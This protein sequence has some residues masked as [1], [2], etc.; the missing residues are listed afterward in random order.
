MKKVAFLISSAGTGGGIQKSLSLITKELG[1]E[2][3]EVTIISLFDFNKT[4]YDYGDATRI[5]KGELEGNIDLKKNFIKTYLECNRLLKLADYD[6]LVVE[7]LGLVPFLRKKI[8]NS[9]SIKIIVRDHSGLS[10]YSKFGLS[11]I[12]LKKTL[13]YANSF[14]VLTEENKK[15][16]IDLSNRFK[17]IIKVI[18]NSIDPDVKEEKYNINSKK[19]IF[20]GRL[21]RE[22][23]VDLLI[24]SFSQS[25]FE[26]QNLDWELDIYGLG[27]EEKNIRDL[28]KKKGLEDRIYLKGYKKNVYNIYHEYSFMVVAS[29]FE[30]FGLA[31]VEAFKVGIPVISFDCN[32][33]PRSIITNN[34]N[35][36]LVKANDV[37]AL[38][39]AINKLIRDTEM[40]KSFSVNTRNGI[41]KYSHQN[42]INEWKKIL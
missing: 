26:L 2:H 17:N 16:Y 32:Y 40:R 25:L 29:R 13:K 5:I 39:S 22:K 19:I 37:N 33:G 4:K 31:I 3:H 20:V 30:S 14:I 1:I 15:E 28:I 7:S 21:G 42:I 23:G 34:E 9:K 35:G 10:N 8:I 18:S 24:E 12:G 41:D 27:P 38:S 36:L 11:W 6:T